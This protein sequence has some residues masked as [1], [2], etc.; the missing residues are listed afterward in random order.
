MPARKLLGAGLLGGNNCYKHVILHALNVKVR[1]SAP[2]PPEA[3]HRMC[4][5]MIASRE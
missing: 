1:E 2:T 3:P 4:C 5:S